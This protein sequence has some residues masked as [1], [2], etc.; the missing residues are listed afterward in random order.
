MNTAIE[1]IKSETLVLIESQAMNMGIS[2]DEYIRR[3]LPADEREMAL[4]PESDEEFEGDMATF[5][6]SSDNPTIYNGTYSRE[7][8]YLDHN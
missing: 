3:L 8:I 2:A 6:E 7:D 1:H 5:A 4:R